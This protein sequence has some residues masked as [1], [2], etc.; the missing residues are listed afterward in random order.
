M[1]AICNALG[2][3]VVPQGGNTSYCGGATPGARGDEIV[4]SLRRMNRIRETDAANFSM[5]AG[6][7]S[8]SPTCRPRRDGRSVLSTLAGRRGQL[9]DRGQ[10]LDQR[11]RPQCAALWRGA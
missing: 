5:V 9:P 3:G 6:R 2:V 1:L 4:L 11:R 8:F 7:A 10:P